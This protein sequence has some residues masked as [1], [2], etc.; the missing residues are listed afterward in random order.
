MPP[1][2]RRTCLKAIFNNEFPVVKDIFAAKSGSESASRQV[3]EIK[4]LLKL[5]MTRERGIKNI[6]TN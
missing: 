4:D 2:F 6:N 5:E 1:K 3:K